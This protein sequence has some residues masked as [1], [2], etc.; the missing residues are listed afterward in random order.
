MQTKKV[1]LAYDAIAPDNSEIRE[2][3]D[4]S[5]AS[6]V[7][8]TLPVGAVSLTVSHVSVDEMWYVLSGQGKLWRSKPGTPQS[9]VINLEP[10]LA[11]SIERSTHFQFK[12]T[13]KEALTLVIATIPPWPGEAEAIREKDFWVIH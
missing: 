13:G 4:V 2:L 5:E 9:M 6:M 8:C 11:I 12:N 1:A 10:G 3:V 7:H